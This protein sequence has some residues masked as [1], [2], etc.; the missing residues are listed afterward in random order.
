MGFRRIRTPRLLARTPRRGHR[1][2]IELRLQQASA[3]NLSFD[4]AWTFVF[5]APFVVVKN[6]INRPGLLFAFQADA[7]SGFVDFQH[8]DADDFAGA[9]FLSWVADEVIGQL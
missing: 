1:V 8:G 6:T 3:V 4:R 9:D 5:F 7:F 2:G